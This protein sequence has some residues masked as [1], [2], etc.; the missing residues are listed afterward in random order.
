MRYHLVF[1]AGGRHVPARRPQAHGQDGRGRHRRA[2]ANCC[3][4]TPRST[5]TS[6]KVEDDG[7][8]THSALALLKF[9]T[10]EDLAAVGNLAGFLGSFTVTGTNDPR[11]QLQARMRFIAFTAQFVQR[12]YDP[13]SPDIGRLEL[14]VRAEVLR[15]ADTPDYFSTRPTTDLQDILRDT[16]TLPL[17]KLLNTGAVRSIS[18]HGRIDRDLFWKGS[19]AKDTLIGWEE[20]ARQAG[21]ASGDGRR[22]PPSRRAHSGN[23][24]TRS[25]TA[26]PPATW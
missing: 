5:A 7:A 10:F 3:A 19:F 25:T 22:A 13:L 1:R 9:R 4:T 23:A 16:P 12:E 18:P 24:S 8:L 20:R 26:W 14:D 2:S 11:L 15:G 6:T 17:E 21:S